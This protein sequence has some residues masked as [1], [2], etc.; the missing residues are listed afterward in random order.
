MKGRRAWTDVIHTLRE[1]KC[2]PRLLYSVKLSIT[3]Y[4]VTKVFHHK[5]KFTHYL[6]VN[7]AL[8]KITTEKNQYKEKNESL[9]KTR[10]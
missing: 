6:S 9:E 2:Q 7:P 8:Q 4:G 1:H 10:R 3:I 5:T